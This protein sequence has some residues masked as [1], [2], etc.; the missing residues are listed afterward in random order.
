MGVI[1][2]DWNHLTSLTMHSRNLSIAPCRH[3][4]TQS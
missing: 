1:A 2:V 4:P 3:A